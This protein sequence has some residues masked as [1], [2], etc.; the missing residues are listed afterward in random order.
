MQKKGYNEL[1]RMAASIK[2]S[3]L[4]TEETNNHVHSHYSFSP[5]SPTDIVT[6]ALKAGI[7]TVGL[8]DHD[9]VAG[10]MNLS[11]RAKL[12]V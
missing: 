4:K 12:W 8:M 2:N 1:S 11:Q 9:S 7:Q 6:E 3:V 5:Y 10:L